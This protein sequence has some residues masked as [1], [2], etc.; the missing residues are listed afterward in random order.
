MIFYERT[1]ARTLVTDCTQRFLFPKAFFIRVQEVGRAGSRNTRMILESL[2]ATSLALLTDPRCI[3]RHQGNKVRQ[4]C[5]GSG[6]VRGLE[7]RA[8][9]HHTAALRGRDDLERSAV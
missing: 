7:A 1:C 6:H 4:H 3:A 8:P 5:L 9:T 2:P